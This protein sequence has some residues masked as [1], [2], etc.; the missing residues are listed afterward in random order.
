MQ[1]LIVP[2]RRHLTLLDGE[3]NWG[4]DGDDPPADPR[5]T[6]VGLSAVGALALAAERRDLGPVPLG[7]VDGTLYAGGRVPPFDPRR[8][9]EALRASAHDA[10]PPALPTGGE[11]AGDFGALLAGRKVRLQLGPRVVREPGALVI[12]GLPLG[13]SATRSSGA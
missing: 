8:V 10:G 2:W 9:V 1:D 5:Y 7:L 6:G 4:T 13:V 12:T 3:G 11:V